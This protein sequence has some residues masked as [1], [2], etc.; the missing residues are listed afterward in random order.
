M[1]DNPLD[2]CSFFYSYSYT[3]LC[4]HFYWINDSNVK[5]INFKYIILAP[6]KFWSRFATAYNIFN[7]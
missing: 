2:M 7:V 5:Y 6:Q 3:K 1:I 4:I